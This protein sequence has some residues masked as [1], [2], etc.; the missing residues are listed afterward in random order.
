MFQSPKRV[1]PSHG[2]TDC[3]SDGDV[4]Q[5]Q[6]QEQEEGEAGGGYLSGA[7]SDSGLVDT[8]QSMNLVVRN[9]QVWSVWYAPCEQC[10][11]DFACV[12]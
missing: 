2:D 7:E 9:L 3:G 1:T 11:G 10:P 4:G 12:V 5:E 8:R 6:E